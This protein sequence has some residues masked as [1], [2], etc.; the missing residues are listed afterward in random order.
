[1]TSRLFKYQRDGLRFDAVAGLT[2]AAVVIPKS[3][4]FASIAGLPV[5][6]GLYVALVPMFVYAL[7][8]TSR[9]LSVSST[10][11]LAILTAAELAVVVPGGEPGKMMA[12]AYTLAL[13]VGGFLLLAGILRLGFLANFISDPIL[14]GFK[15]GI[16]LVIV[17]D[18][19]PKLLGVHIEKGNFFHDLLSILSHVRET[20]HA[21]VILAV[22]MLAILFGMERFFPKTPAPLV[23][24]VLGVAA[25]RFLGLKV[26][27][28]ALTGHIPAGIPTPAIP[29]FSLVRVLWPGA[30][31]MALMSFTESIAAGRAFAAHNDPPPLPN[32]EL[33]ALGAANLAGSFFQCFPAGGG[34]SQTAVN[35]RAGARTQVSELVTVAMV[36]AT[37]L[38]L[39]PLISLLPQATLAAVVVVTTLPLLSTAGFR[40]ILEVRR[41]EFLWALATCIGVVVLGTLRGILVAVA[42]SVLTLFYQANHPHVYAVRRKPGTDVFRPQSADHPD[43]ETIPGLLIVRTEGRMTFASAPQVRQRLRDLVTEAHPQVVILECSAIPDFEYTALQALIE[44]EEKLRESGITLW[45]TALNPEALNVV[46]RSPLGRALGSERMFFNLRDAVTA[47]EKKGRRSTGTRSSPDRS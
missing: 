29:D 19:L 42:I 21:T 47:F 38:F 2:T 46:K 41:T 25:A 11:T 32:W 43:D 35:S 7:L 31:G 10:S 6:A 36:L 4:A 15:A 28:V 17:V 33:I 9:P 12:A 39:S 20:N 26:F 13:L 3:M 8:G 44:A 5:Q 16:G 45:L 24:V 40:S 37:L 18:Q 30:L 27:G 14:T 1:M 22:A 34:T 23:A